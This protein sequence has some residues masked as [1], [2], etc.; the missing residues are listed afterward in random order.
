MKYFLTTGFHSLQPLIYFN[1]IKVQFSRSTWIKYYFLYP[2]LYIAS[3]LRLGENWCISI[4]QLTQFLQRHEYVREIDQRMFKG[5]GHSAQDPCWH[6]CKYM[7]MYIYLYIHI[8]KYMMILCMFSWWCCVLQKINK[9]E[10][11]IVNAC[12]I[13]F[14]RSQ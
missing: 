13:T 9:N 2:Y 11:F 10:Y 4:L 14:V 8:Y 12:V 3:V 5:W 6:M 1:R 7:S